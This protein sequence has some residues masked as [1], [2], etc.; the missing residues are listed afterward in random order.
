MAGGWLGDARSTHGLFHRALQDRF[1]EV[2]APALATLGVHVGARRRKHPLPLECAAG[3]W[4]LPTEREGQLDPPSTGAEVGGVE[5]AHSPDLPCQ[6][7]LRDCREKPD[8]VTIAL[9]GPD[10]ELV[11]F[12][13]DVLHAQLCALEEPEPRAIEQE[14][15]QSGYPSHL[16][17]DGAHLCPRKNHGQA[18]GTL[19][20]YDAVKP[21]DRASQH[22]PVEEEQR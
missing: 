21:A 17:E 2:V 8:P 1:V 12:E 20:V 14:D 19:R 7:R 9:A 15:H 16:L 5:A 22:L 3:P 4:I 13:V 6:R 11:R 18:Q 10:H